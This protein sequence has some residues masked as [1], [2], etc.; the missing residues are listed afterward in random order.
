MTR[1]LRWIALLVVLGVF[2]TGA[3]VALGWSGNGNNNG[4][5]NKPDRGCPAHYTL[6]PVA[7]GGELID[8]NGDGMLCYRPTQQEGVSQVVDNTSNQS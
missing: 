2:G 6:G 4:W 1:I 5:D 7:A 8:L 3:G